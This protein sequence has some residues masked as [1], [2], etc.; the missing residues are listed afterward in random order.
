MLADRSDWR[1][2]QRRQVQ[3]LGDA[4]GLR[5]VLTEPSLFGRNGAAMVPTP[6]EPRSVSAPRPG[7]A[8]FSTG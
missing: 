2:K 3:I 7:A 6:Y 4:D 1:N 8:G 5:L